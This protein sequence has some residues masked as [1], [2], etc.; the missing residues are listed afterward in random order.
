MN[1]KKVKSIALF[2]ILT[3]LAF[4]FSYLET[5]IPLGI[6]IPGIKLGLA[7]IVVVSALYL[8]DAK[9]AFAVSVIRI[10]LVSITFGNAFGLVYSLSGGLLSFVVMALAKKTK[11]SVMGVSMLGGIFHNIGQLIAA[12]FVTQ[13]SR[14]AYYFPVL[15]AAGLITGFLIGLV[16]KA[17]TQRLK[18]DDKLK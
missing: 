1:N 9:R 15:L 2:G 16:S 11:L 8:L 10:I 13:T 3:A 17:V 18:L 14:L 4:G 12:A 7:N 6:G 5:L